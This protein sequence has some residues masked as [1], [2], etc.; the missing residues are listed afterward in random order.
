M[1]SPQ[2]PPVE[3]RNRDG[4]GCPAQVVACVHFGGRVLALT[5]RQEVQHKFPVMGPYSVRLAMP[6]NG[7]VCPCHG[8]QWRSGPEDGTS[9][10]DLPSAQ[11]EFD[12]RAAELRASDVRET[13]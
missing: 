11:A 1:P 9:W 3:R 12:R 8:E 6:Y 10:P 2:A 7:D 4:C 13:S 5:N